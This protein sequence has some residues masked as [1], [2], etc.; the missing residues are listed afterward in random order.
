MAVPM[1]IART[2]IEEAFA[3][4]MDLDLVLGVKNIG[5]SSDLSAVNAHG[6]FRLV[7]QDWGSKGR[8]TLVAYTPP[9][10]RQPPTAETGEPLVHVHVDWDRVRFLRVEKV[11]L[12]LIGA[13]IRISFVT[14][15]PNGEVLLAFYA[16]QDTL[17]YQEFAQKRAI[18]DHPLP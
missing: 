2:S 5:K 6:H 8:E 10:E 4:L 12:P 18:A 15:S 1:T 13:D 9:S 11:H 7:V 16:R 14:A 3:D 17:A